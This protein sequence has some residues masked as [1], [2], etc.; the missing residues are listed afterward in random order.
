[1][2]FSVLMQMKIKFCKR[3]KCGSKTCLNLENL[4]KTTYGLNKPYKKSYMNMIMGT[5]EGEESGF[6]QPNKTFL[7]FPHKWREEKIREVL[8]LS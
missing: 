6:F 1:M 7:V 5:M 8:R 4:P 2:K 3:M